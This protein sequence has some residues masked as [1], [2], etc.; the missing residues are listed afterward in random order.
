MT[1]PAPPAAP[2]L[3]SVIVPAYQVAPLVAGAIAS[4]RAQDLAD[5]EALVIDDGS[6][7]GSGQAAE[8]AWGGDPRFRL[9]RQENRGLSAARNA[10]IA[11]ARGEWLA[12]LDGDDAFAP[13]FLAGLVAAAR[14]AGLPWA[15]SALDLVYP[16]GQRVAH[17]ARHGTPDPAGLAEATLPLTD[18]VE[19]ARLFPSAW[20]KV[21]R[22]ELFADLR[23]REG[24]WFEDH[25]V[26]WALAA[27]TGAIR[28]LPEPLYRHR[29]G[30]PGQITGA[31]DERVFQQ[32]PVLDRLRPL[33]A[34]RTRAAEGMAQLASRLVHERAEVLASQPRR[35][36]FVAAAREWFGRNGLA[37]TR[38]GGADLSPALALEMRGE[39][40]LTV[41]VPAGAD[42]QAAAEVLATRLPLGA[43][44]LALGPGQD[45]L[46]QA[47]AAARGRYT[48]V[49][50]AGDRPLPE[51]ILALMD[52]A[53]RQGAP[54]ALGQI[55]TPAGPHDGWTD[56]RGA[57]P[58]GAAAALP[59][60][61]ALRL[62]PSAG[63]MLVRTQ[64]LAGLGPLSVPLWHPLAEAELVLR[65]ALALPAALCPQPAVQRPAPA[66]VAPAEAA[67]W[68]RALPE[69]P[70]P[71]GWRAV[72]AL[73]ALMPGL[74][75]ARSLRG[76][77]ARAGA[78]LA[79]AGL[80]APPGAAPADPGASRALSRLLG[81]PPAPP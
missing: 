59:G 40:P 21:Y 7:D 8:A 77:A 28:Y 75:P 25:E 48:L 55:L 43:Q 65:A 80:R 76:G 27:R 38:A 4:L 70:L 54:L 10:G 24:T 47:L 1:P 3:V 37:F 6:D 9:I 39:V 19:T 11:L 42:G 73:R 60:A 15:A 71:P 68:A 44:I 32:F 74:P 51:G 17:S 64:A 31:D 2:P 72:L 34:T 69:L 35:A 62:H 45:G 58:P 46:P 41:L 57:P 53:L 78:A 33:V 16:D 20:N 56:N 61:M 36:R 5:F 22:R 49:L 63:R 50:P 81:L 66:T 79:L 18:A 14:R 29:R 13:G 52:T 23:F 67:R 30:R 12:F 26:Y